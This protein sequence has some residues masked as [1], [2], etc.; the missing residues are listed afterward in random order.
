MIVSFCFKQVRN[1][2]NEANS[3]KHPHGTGVQSDDGSVHLI[4]DIGVHPND[5]GV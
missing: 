3:G 4:H 5:S 2:N 1:K